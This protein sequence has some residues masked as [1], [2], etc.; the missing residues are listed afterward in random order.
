MTNWNRPTR[1]YRGHLEATGEAF[2]FSGEQRDASWPY[3]LSLKKPAPKACEQCGQTKGKIMWHSEDYSGPPWGPHIGK[4]ALCFACHMILHSRF[5]QAEGFC[6]YQALLRLGWRL[7][8]PL[9]NFGQVNQ[10]LSGTKPRSLVQMASPKTNWY[11]WEKE[12]RPRIEQMED[13]FTGNDDAFLTAGSQAR[14][15]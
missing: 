5:R 1:S 12:L 11:L 6:R 15:F 13:R 8:S 2:E 10:V 3:F 7:K 14:L 9:W 4:Y